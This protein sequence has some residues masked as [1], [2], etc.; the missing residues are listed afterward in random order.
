MPVFIS[1]PFH[2]GLVEKK[3]I[4]MCILK[5]VLIFLLYRLGIVQKL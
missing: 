4:F 2:V 3:V 1:R 5:K